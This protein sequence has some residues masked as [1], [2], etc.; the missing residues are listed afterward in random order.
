MQDA[1][2]GNDQALVIVILIGIYLLARDGISVVKM[3]IDRN[4]PDDATQTAEILSHVK[5]LEQRLESYM[6]AQTDRSRAHG[7][8]LEARRTDVRI[9]Y[10]KAEKLGREISQLN[11]RLD[12]LDS[13]V[14]S[15]SQKLKEHD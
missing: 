14:R 6:E 10:D 11:G 2:N 8:T 1:A 9:L 12:G 3:F 5:S 13:R 15:F 7:E 4:K